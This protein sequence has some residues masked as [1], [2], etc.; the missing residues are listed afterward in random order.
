MESEP[1]FKALQPRP[2]E[3]P[4]LVS[5]LF[6]P[7][8]SPRAVGKPTRALRERRFFIY[9]CTRDPSLPALPVLDVQVLFYALRLLKEKLEWGEK[10]RPVILQTAAWLNSLASQSTPGL[11]ITLHDSIWM[12]A[13]S[14]QRHYLPLELNASLVPLG[15]RAKQT[16]LSSGSD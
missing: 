11:F 7:R 12:A 6:T 13:S 15:F 8:Q 10:S 2:N 16:L 9:K 5:K 3:W 4:L 14:Y 1:K